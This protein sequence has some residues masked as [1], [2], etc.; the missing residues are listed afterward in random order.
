MLLA[1]RDVWWHV[2]VLKL[3]IDLRWVYRPSSK[4][5]VLHNWKK[6]FDYIQ[7]EISGTIPI[8]YNSD[9]SIACNGH[10]K[11]SQ[12]WNP[13]SFRRTGT[14]CGSCYIDATLVGLKWTRYSY[15]KIISLVRQSSNILKHLCQFSNLLLL[16]QLSWCTSWEIL[17]NKSEELSEY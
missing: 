15:F 16:W 10:G 5:A 4:S 3:S 6:Q 8:P 2:V 1:V 7:T 12:F 11:G 17:L 14:S 9:V 13:S